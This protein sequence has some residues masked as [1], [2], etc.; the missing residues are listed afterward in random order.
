MRFLNMAGNRFFAWLMSAVLGQ[1]VKDT[2]CGTKVIHRDDYERIMSHRH[3]IAGDDP[4]GDFEFL[5][6]ASLLGLKILNLPIRY[7]ARTYGETNIQRFSGG[8]KLVRFA[9]GGF[10][11]IWMDPVER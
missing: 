1:Y 7:G 4:F 2:L 6:G 8:G 10:R 9:A 11:R 5:L 3:E